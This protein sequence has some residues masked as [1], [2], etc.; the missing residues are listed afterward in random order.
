MQ[1]KTV[2]SKSGKNRGMANAV[3]L[4][5][6]LLVA[7]LGLL[8]G[9]APDGVETAAQ[10]QRL[11]VELDL[12]GETL[13]SLDA[14]ISQQGLTRLDL[15]GHEISEETFLAL[16]EGLPFCEILWSV[17]LGGALYDCTLK[18]LTC[19]SLTEKDIGLLA[20][21]PSL[22]MLDARGSQC[23]EA[24]SAF[25]TLHPECEVLWTVPVCGQAVDNT[26][27]WL[28]LGAREDIDAEKLTAQLAC[29]P[30]LTDVNLVGSALTNREKAALHIAYPDIRFYW[31]VDFPEAQY[32]S[33]DERLDFTVVNFEGI[34]DLATVVQC[35]MN[36][37]WVDVSTHGFESSEMEQICAQFPDTRFVWVV[38]VGKYALRTDAKVFYGRSSGGDRLLRDE[39]IEPL[40]YCT[41]LEALNL[42]RQAL[43]DLSPLSGLVNLRVLV[44]SQNDIADLSPI[45]GLKN[46]VYLEAYRNKIADLRPL[47]D[48]PALLD[49]NLS[50]NEISD[51]SP[52]L[53]NAQLER[54]WLSRNA[55]A[56]DD[57]QQ[58]KLRLALPSAELEFAATNM[59]LGWANHDRYFAV[60]TIWSTNQMQE[61]SAE[62][63]AE[64]Q[65]RVS[66]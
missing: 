20:Y 63:E 22:T 43:T 58:E 32:R 21:F 64:A 15:R 35:F 41:E 28:D 34:E 8:W 49:L 29:L 37:V 24:L 51:A 13:P 56:E 11:T 61:L 7:Y 18:S 53:G 33:T 27:A 14:L 25:A 31:T 1:R 30:S 44:I 19:D 17:P 60:K 55:L 10:P 45:S 3:L 16:S 65:Q 52:I 36:P 50:Y 9:C 57:V 26:D 54:L 6:L 39:D 2:H 59:N 66:P 46:L 48:L 42:S 47:A 4:P 5:A 23:Y 62:E 38:R 40:R 12:R